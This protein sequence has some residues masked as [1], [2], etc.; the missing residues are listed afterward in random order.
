MPD[1]GF[2]E[3]GFV[4]NG[5]NFGKRIGADVALDADFNVLIEAVV[6][7]NNGLADGDGAVGRDTR[8]GGIVE[9]FADFLDAGFVASL[10]IA[11]GVEIGVVGE[12]AVAAGKGQRIA[13]AGSFDVDEVGIFLLKFVVFFLGENDL[14]LRDG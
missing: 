7:N 10:G 11:S 3:R 2:A 8:N 5:R 9:L 4:G 6:V 1:D 13:N 12:V 14:L